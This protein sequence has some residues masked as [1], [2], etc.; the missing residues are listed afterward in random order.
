[1]KLISKKLAGPFRNF[2]VIETN[3]INDNRIKYDRYLRIIKAMPKS[4]LKPRY[5]RTLIPNAAGSW[6][7]IRIK[8]IINVFTTKVQGH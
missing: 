8:L 4:D 2:L 6:I 7:K 5:G 3:P 1:M